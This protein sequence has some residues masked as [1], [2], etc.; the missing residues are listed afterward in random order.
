MTLSKSQVDRLGDQLRRGID[1]DSQ[2]A[3]SDYREEFAEALAEVMDRV[4]AALGAVELTGRRK[5]LDTV[6]AKLNRGSMRLSQMQDIA[7]CRVVV[8]SL[9]DQDHATELLTEQFLDA[10]VEDLRQQPHSGYRAV[11]VIV[12]ASTG[13][14]V[15]VQVRTQ[16]Q[17]EWSQISEKVADI[18][19]LGIK[20]DGGP[21]GVRRQ[22]ESLSDAG[23]Q[24]DRSRAQLQSLLAEAAT[25]G[26]SGGQLGDA[27]RSGDLTRYDDVQR[28]AAALDPEIAR[29]RAVVAAGEA[30]FHTQAERIVDLAR[31][32]FGEL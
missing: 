10:V 17:N 4:T 18:V 9:S 22:L 21:P 11:H 2:R 31:E 14:I 27:L 12:S 29:L 13:K 6:V 20:Y 1:D 28:T 26:A 19:G 8:P 15:E 30:A 7:G 23:A 32:E 16:L 24:L 3:Y 25:R 5:T